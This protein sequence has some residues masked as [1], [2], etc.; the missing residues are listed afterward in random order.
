MSPKVLFINTVAGKGSVGRIVTG[1]SRTLNKK[2]VETLIAYGRWA[3]PQGHV[4]Y[5]IGSDISV[6]LHGT[7][8]RITDRHGLYSVKATKALIEK[9]K[10]FDPDI[11]HLH[12]V[13]GY[14][15]NYKL[16]FDFLK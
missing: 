1:L 6:Y 4:S 11:I 2:D 15:V 5:R 13:H 14:Y 16:L 3:P 7:L 10:E 12:N 9:I 8:S